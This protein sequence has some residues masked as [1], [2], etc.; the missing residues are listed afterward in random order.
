MALEYQLNQLSKNDASL[1]DIL[2]TVKG[3]IEK[4]RAQGEAQAPFSWAK[5]TR[6][7]YHALAV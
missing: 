5:I 2:D 6:D 4:M 3:G 7:G 1:D